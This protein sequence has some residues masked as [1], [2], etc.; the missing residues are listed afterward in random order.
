VAYLA[1]FKSPKPAYDPSL[2]AMAIPR[3]TLLP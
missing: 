1:N 3:V 2:P